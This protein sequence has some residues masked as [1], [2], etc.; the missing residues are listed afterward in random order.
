LHVVTRRS[1][2]T[3]A[4]EDPIVA[5][6]LAF[7]KHNAYDLIGVSDVARATGTARN[8]LRRHFQ[9]AL[10]RTPHD[11]ILRLRLQRAKV[12]LSETKL[13]LS[14]IAGSTGFRTASYFS[15]AFKENT[16]STPG[17]YRASVQT[18]PSQ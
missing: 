5:A 16:G 7:I 2:D 6:A 18:R 15:Y 10:G 8:T 12:L 1:S 14:E 13:G 9:E 4:I 17:E 3:F 11:E